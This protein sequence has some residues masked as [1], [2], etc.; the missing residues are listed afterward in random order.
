MKIKHSDPVQTINELIDD[1]CEIRRG[2][3]PIK[4]VAAT[5]VICALEAAQK[6]VLWFYEQGEGRH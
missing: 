5:M 3:Q 6:A 2:M 4:R 1:F